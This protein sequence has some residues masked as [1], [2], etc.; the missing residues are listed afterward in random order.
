MA[1]THNTER[2]STSVASIAGRLLNGKSL[3]EAVTWLEGIALTDDAA[4]D[5]DRAHA[6]ALLGAVAS[7]RTLAGS[8]LTQRT[9]SKVF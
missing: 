6:L 2:T 9:L 4:N 7:M 8:A 5:N 1:K 3:K